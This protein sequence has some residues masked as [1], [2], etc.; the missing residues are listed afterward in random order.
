[1][2]LTRGPFYYANKPDE[3]LKS[4]IFLSTLAYYIQWNAMLL[5]KPLF[6]QD[7]DYKEKRWTFEGIIER[8]KSIRITENLIDGI[9]IKKEISKPDQEQQQILDLLNIKLK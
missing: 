6:D 4:H 8:L 3:C 1:M 7:G 2:S 9:V 5:L